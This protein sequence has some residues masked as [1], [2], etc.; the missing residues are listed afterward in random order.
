M[1]QQCTKQRKVERGPTDELAA[2]LVL[3]SFSL[4][5]ILHAGYESM[6]VSIYITYSCW[7][8]TDSWSYLR[9]S[10]SNLL[11]LSQLWPRRAQ[12]SCK[13]KSL[14]SSLIT[15]QLHYYEKVIEQHWLI[16][17]QGDERKEGSFSLSLNPLQ[18]QMFW[19]QKGKDNYIMLNTLPFS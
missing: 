5:Q 14:F 9:E 4:S 1:V 19:G 18:G 13:L 12:S 3:I 15:N 16:T 8:N 11:F 7:L 17:F 2:S 6:H 10:L